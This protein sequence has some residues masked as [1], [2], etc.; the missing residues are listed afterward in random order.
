MTGYHVGR[1]SGYSYSL[2]RRIDLRL[3]I[4]YGKVRLV[5]MTAFRRFGS[6][7]TGMVWSFP[8]V[9]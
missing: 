1:I 6:Q 4:Q 3:S 5:T 8:I 7:L 9:S 2:G